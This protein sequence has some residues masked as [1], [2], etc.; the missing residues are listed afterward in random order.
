MIKNP[1][2]YTTVYEAGVHASNHF[3]VAKFLN[4]SFSWTELTRLGP[5]A[6]ECA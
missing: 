5:G 3:I 4:H 1:E 6:E 2:Y